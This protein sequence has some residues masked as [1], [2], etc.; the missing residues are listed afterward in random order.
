MGY[1]LFPLMMVLIGCVVFKETLNRLQWAAIIVAAAGVGLQFWL[2][3]SVSWATAWVCLTYPIYYGLRRWQG[4]PALMGLFVD[5]SVIA[6]IALG[7]LLWQ[8]SSIS[9]VTGS[10][11]MGLLVIGLGM[12]SA[13]AMQTNLKASQVLPMNT[14]GMLSYL[15][16]ALMF[17]LSIFVLHEAVNGTM[18]ASFALIWVGVL[19]MIVNAIRASKKSHSTAICD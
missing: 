19:L 15:E 17:L 11:T 14:F 5:L 9:I 6:P 4:V 3:G 8:N 7:F 13:L 16:P 10:M 2:A 18:I 12:I 1:F